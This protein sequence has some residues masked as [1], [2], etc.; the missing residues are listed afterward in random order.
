MNRD[1]AN[2]SR[3]RKPNVTFKRVMQ[4]IDLFQILLLLEHTVSTNDGKKDLLQ[5]CKPNS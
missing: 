2:S 1:T 5:T 4:I 3:A